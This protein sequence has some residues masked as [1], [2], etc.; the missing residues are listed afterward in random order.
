M[1]GGREGTGLGV[2]VAIEE[3]QPLVEK[4]SKILADRGLA[5]ASLAHQQDG[6]FVHQTAMNQREEPSGHGG[7]VSL[8][9]AHARAREGTFAWAGSTPSLSR[10]RLQ[11][12]WD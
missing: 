7:S 1:R 6:L 9:A 8:Y 12:W 5:T 10:T 11:S 3:V 2:L 4:G